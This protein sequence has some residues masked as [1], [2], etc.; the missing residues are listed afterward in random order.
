MAFFVDV[1]TAFASVVRCFLIEDTVSRANL[2]DRLV[3]GGID[4]ALV[5]EVVAD[6]CD[7]GFWDEAG[8]SPHLVASV[9]D[10]FKHTWATLEGSVDVLNMGSGCSAGNPCA[11]VFFCLAFSKIL[12]AIRIDL[13][14]RGYL[15]EYDTQAVAAFSGTD[16]DIPGPTFVGQEPSYADDAVFVLH[17]SAD[18]VVE[19]YLR[20]RQ[21]YLVLF[22]CCRI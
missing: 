13:A 17:A 10:W 11:D 7:L 16:C 20:G 6:M 5:E 18:A 3:T 22:L 4:A 1:S 15:V 21:P 12:K 14:R 2:I 9:H 19:P 8:A